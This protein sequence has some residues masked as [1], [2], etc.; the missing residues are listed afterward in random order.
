MV[1]DV[2]ALSSEETDVCVNSITWRMLENGMP[3][4]KLQ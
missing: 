2:E 4:V 1:D 3:T